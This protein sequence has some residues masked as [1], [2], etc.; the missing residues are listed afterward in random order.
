MSP[1][2]EERDDVVLL[3]AVARGDEESLAV[4][5]DRHAGWL[6]IR[7]TR[8]CALPDVVDH[9]V[10]D[11]FLA[12]WRDAGAYR[13]TGDVAA[14]IWGIG[15]RRENGPG[16][17]CRGVRRS[18]RRSSRP[19]MRYWPVAGAARCARGDRAGRLDLR[20]GSRPAGR[21]GRDCQV[22]LS[23]C[24]GGA[25]RRARRGAGRTRPDGVS[26]RSL[27]GIMTNSSPGPARPVAGADGHPGEDL[28]AG[29]A[30]GTAGTVVAWSVEAHLTGC[31]RCRSAL[32]V[33]ADAERLARNRSVLLARAAI[34]DGGR[35]RKVLRRCG[36]PDY[37]LGL[38]AATPS[39]RRSWLL[40][41]VGVLAVVAA[42]AVAVR[43]GWIQ[44]GRPGLLEGHPGPE[45]LAPFVLV[46]PLLVLAGVAAA[47]LPMFDPACL[48]AV[49]AP[50]SGFT[51]LLVRSV[52]AL[53]AA[54]IPVVAAAFF[55]PGPGWLPV[56][57][58]L[59]SL[60]LSAFALAAAT[61]LAPRTAA[62]TAG[63]L[64]AVPALLLG[65]ATAHGALL[66]VQPDAQFACA[67][68]LCAC[69][70]VLYLRHDRFEWG[71]MR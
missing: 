61:V 28:L 41:V 4:L 24:P 51:L 26:P 48:L 36:I 32:S 27:G 43:Y 53:A 13:G 67:A 58:L 2:T 5:Y 42:E 17:A 49:A 10:Q 66:I 34:G 57:L 70:V 23:P 1:E 47:F 35:V 55:L 63:T 18:R 30:A 9:A 3:R 68:A 12:L 45:D 69:A 20:G 21:G 25:A 64:W 59:P 19:R 14:F 33:H 22:P 29:Y 15:I 60:A 31:A 39:L 62:I 40:S 7:M 44:A 52:S 65:T 56:A 46:A 37:M 54:L 16:G 11:T 6:T 71:W 50:F 38:L 8:R